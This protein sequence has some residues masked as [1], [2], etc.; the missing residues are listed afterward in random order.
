MKTFMA[1]LGASAIVAIGAV[2]VAIAQQ[3]TPA[4]VVGSGQM[5]MGATATQT[6]PPTVPDTAQ[7]A[8]AVKAGDGG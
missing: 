8:P 2:G 1:I 6:T 5:S 3:Q 4:Q 7:A